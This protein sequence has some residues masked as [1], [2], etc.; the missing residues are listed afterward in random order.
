MPARVRKLM[1]L[2][3]FAAAAAIITTPANAQKRY[4]VRLRSAQAEAR[5]VAGHSRRRYLTDFR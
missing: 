5:D 3:A 2:T 1:A 4:V